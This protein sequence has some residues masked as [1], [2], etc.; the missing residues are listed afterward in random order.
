MST[1]LDYNWVDAIQLPQS[2]AQVLACCIDSQGQ[3]S[4][5]RAEYIHPRTRAVVGALSGDYGMETDF[6]DATDTAYWPAGWYELVEHLG[7]LTHLPVPED[8][9]AYWMLMP[10]L[11][12][13]LLQPVVATDSHQEAGS[14]SIAAE[15][16][17]SPFRRVLQLPSIHKVLPG[18]QYLTVDGTGIVHSSESRPQCAYAVEPENRVWS[19]D[20]GMRR[21]AVVVPPAQP[22]VE[23]YVLSVGEWV[24]EEPERI[25]R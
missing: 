25:M 14:T 23:L 5:I 7:D 19:S 9:V 18:H 11:P 21:V 3:P 2:D 4:R 15:D 22:E 12:V 8:K 1:C 10:D 24:S 13:G 16:D 17:F 6:D 20:T